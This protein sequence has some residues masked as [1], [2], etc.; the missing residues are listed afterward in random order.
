[1]DPG[2]AQ[3]RERGEAAIAEPT[4]AMQTLRDDCLPLRA[5]QSSIS[6]SSSS[7]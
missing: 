2:A 3:H 6:S 7:P 4:I 5:G 1:M